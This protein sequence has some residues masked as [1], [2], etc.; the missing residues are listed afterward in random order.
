M[1]KCPRC[2]RK[3]PNKDA[4]QCDKCMKKFNTF[5]THGVCPNCGKVFQTTQCGKCKNWSRHE[6]WY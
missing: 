4:W 5:I 2:G 3:A 1:P 6:D